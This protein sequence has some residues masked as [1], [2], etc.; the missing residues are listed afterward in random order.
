MEYIG[1]TPTFHQITPPTRIAD[2]PSNNRIYSQNVDVDHLGRVAV[3]YNHNDRAYLKLDASNIFVPLSAAFDNPANLG[4]NLSTAPSCSLSTDITWL[5]VSLTSDNTTFIPETRINVIHLA[6]NGSDVVVKIAE[7]YVAIRDYYINTGPPECIDP[8]D[9]FGSELLIE[10]ASTPIEFQFPRIASPSPDHINSGHANFEEYAGAYLRKNNSSNLHEIA[11][12]L[13]DDAGILKHDNSNNLDGLAYEYTLFCEHTKPAISYNGNSALIMTVWQYYDCSSY[14]ANEEAYNW[15]PVPTDP[16]IVELWPT[17]P[18]FQWLTGDYILAK[19]YD[20]K[21]QRVYQDYINIVSNPNNALDYSAPSVSGK[22][23]TVNRGR[24]EIHFSYHNND[25]TLP[26]YKLSQPF[27]P[28][29]RPSDE[30][31]ISIVK[32]L[33][34]RFHLTVQ[35]RNFNN[36]EIQNKSGIKDLNF[37]LYNAHGQLVQTH[38]NKSNE[39]YYAIDISDLANGMYILNANGFGYTESF[40]IVKY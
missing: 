14:I 23:S 26:T 38:I 16:E 24:D 9:G 2:T 1:T 40:K 39:P 30:E 19:Q 32:E 37:Y 3:V 11:T 7:D 34:N 29:L 20:H 31:S 21:L 13:G 15:P 36:I 10:T 18:A 33:D 8:T 25:N 12:I 22:L 6:D 28:Q 35:N 17:P 4:I 27:A 5:D